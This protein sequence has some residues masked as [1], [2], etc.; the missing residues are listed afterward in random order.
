MNNHSFS[1]PT[2]S[3]LLLLS[4]LSIAA[5]QTEG[6][7]V[8]DRYFVDVTQGSGKNETYH[9]HFIDENDKIVDPTDFRLKQSD[10]FGRA[11]YSFW[12]NDGYNDALYA[13]TMKARTVNED[14][15]KSVIYNY[16]RWQDGEWQLLGEYTEKNELVQPF[17]FFPCDNDRIIVVSWY[18]DLID[19]NSPDRSPFAVMSVNPNKKELKPEK[20]IYHGM[21]DLKSNMSENSFFSHAA[22]A[23]YI[24][25]D[26]YATIINRT[27]GL[28]WCFSLERASLTKAGCILRHLDSK[29]IVKTIRNRGFV[30]A[31]LC[32]QPEKEGTVLVSALEEAALK[33]DVGNTWG[34]LMEYVQKDPD[35]SP[36]D[37][38]KLYN[39]RINELRRRSP[40]VVWYRIHPENGRVEKLDTPP[41]GADYTR[42]GEIASALTGMDKDEWRPLPDGSVRMGPLKVVMEEPKK[43]EEKS[44]KNASTTPKR[45]P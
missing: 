36:K 5:Q 29:D 22:N 38:E 4:S 24:V 43:E 39:D 2:L 26:K 23:N 33:N 27:T 34:E 11:T 41:I 37:R 10:G 35:L 32:A 25:T 17:R 6:Q 14:G 45:H 21:D 28:Y 13:L 3:A 44:D 7:W 31:V 15:S 19:N 9:N 40:N 16:V 18:R 30:V 1:R 12:F 42:Q 8:G 20:S